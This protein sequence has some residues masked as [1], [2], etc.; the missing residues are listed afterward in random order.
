MVYEELS[1][2]RGRVLDGR[3]SERVAV[4]DRDFPAVRAGRCE[5]FRRAE[6]TI[7]GGSLPRITVQEV[8]EHERH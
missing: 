5:A 2:L 1:P 4:A 8:T 7:G 6:A 3:V